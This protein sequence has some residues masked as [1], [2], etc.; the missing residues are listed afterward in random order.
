MPNLDRK[1]PPLVVV[2][3]LAAL[4][5]SISGIGPQFAIPAQ[6]RSLLAGLLAI[7]GVAVVLLGVLAF[8]AART[9]TNPIQPELAS[10]LVTGGV[11]RVTRN[12]MYLGMALLLSGWAMWLSALLPWAGPVLFVLYITRFQIRPEERALKD[13]FGEAYSRYAGHVRRWL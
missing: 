2:A 8:R 9:T 4:M 10:S 7:A 13:I 6:G 11:Y 5:W 12:P 1:I 3:L